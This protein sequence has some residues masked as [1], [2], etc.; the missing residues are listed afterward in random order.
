M[1]ALGRKVVLAAFLGL[2][3]VV[4]LPSAASA[5]LPIFGPGFKA[6]DP[7]HNSVFDPVHHPKRPNG[8]MSY[9]DDPVTN[10][11]IHIFNQ[12]PWQ[13]TFKVDGSSRTLEPGYSTLCVKPAPFVFDF[14]NG[15]QMCRLPFYGDRHT[16]AFQP[17]FQNMVCMTQL[18]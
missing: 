14:W 15:T 18:Q 5:Q 10:Q 9:F 13:I 6:T 8:S 16:V 17:C 11:V 7:L 2:A 12:T 3:A 4:S 1:F